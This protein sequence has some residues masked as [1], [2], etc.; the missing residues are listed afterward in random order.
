M[1]LTPAFAAPA[2]AVMMTVAVHANDAIADEIISCD[3]LFANLFD[4]TQSRSRQKESLAT[5][6]ASILVDAQIPLTNEVVRALAIERTG[7][8]V[9]AEQLARVAAYEREAFLRTRMPPLLCSVIDQSA[10]ALRPRVWALGDWRLARR[11][12]TPDVQPLWQGGIALELLDQI[13]LRFPPA[14]GQLRRQALEAVARVLG[15]VAAYVPGDRQQWEELRRLVAEKAFNDNP[16]GHTVQQAEAEQALLDYDPPI[17][18]ANLYFG[19]E[20]SALTSPP[21][22]PAKLRLPSKSESGTPFDQVVKMRLGGDESRTS[23]LLAYLQGWSFVRDE[24]GRPPSSTEYADRWKYDQGSV[25][26]EEE[27]F[28]TAFPEEESPERLIGLLEN[29]LPRSGQL[30]RLMGVQVVDSDESTVVP[31]A[32]PGQRWRRDDGAILTVSKVEG[33]AVIGHLEEANGEHLLWASGQG[34]LHKE[35][36]LELPKGL[37]LVTFDVDVEPSSLL[38]VFAPKGDIEVHRYRRPS[39][40]RAGQDFLR[41]GT[42]QLQVLASDADA[43]RAKVIE[44]LSGRLELAEGE[45]Y[46]ASFTG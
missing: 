3:S 23:A 9:S 10:V 8:Q 2:R 21:F 20:L 5:V 12:A 42:V 24:L 35:F 29:G 46:V 19:L 11:I 43:A 37:W 31:A 17:G 41:A 28:A 45:V 7:R 6:L 4:M 44:A 36:T 39:E 40:P 22:T 18:A 13:L 26:R 25:R 34:K 1:V 33:L 16:A 14:S 30:A 32:A 15:P 27:L 38:S